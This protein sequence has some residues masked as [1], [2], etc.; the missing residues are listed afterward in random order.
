MAQ[1]CQRMAARSW[2]C[3]RSRACWPSADMDP[4]KPRGVL[5]WAVWRAR[6]RRRA[7]LRRAQGGATTSACQW[8][9]AVAPRRHRWSWL[10][11]RCTGTGVVLSLLRVYRRAGTVLLVEGQRSAQRWLKVPPA[12]RQRSQTTAASPTTKA[13]PQLSAGRLRGRQ[14]QPGPGAA[15]LQDGRRREF[16]LAAIV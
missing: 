16:A 6:Q 14:G 8:P 13:E 1:T 4:R 7:S 9:S 3:A 12:L 15:I 11:G 2:A 5:V 10:A